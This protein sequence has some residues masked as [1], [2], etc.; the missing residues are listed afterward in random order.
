M[1]KENKRQRLSTDPSKKESE[2]ISSDKNGIGKIIH[3]C[4]ICGYIRN[5][6]GN[7]APQLSKQYNVDDGQ[8]EPCGECAIWI[9]EYRDVEGAIIMGFDYA[10]P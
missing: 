2:W 8:P 4:E 7:D 1:P 5:I 10:K 6:V 9:N 3:T